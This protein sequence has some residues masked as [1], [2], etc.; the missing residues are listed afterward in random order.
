MSL[1]SL[2]RAFSR[3]LIATFSFVRI[4][5]AILTFPKVPLPSDFPMQMRIKLVRLNLNF[6]YPSLTKD[7]VA[8][9]DPFGMWIYFTF[10]CFGSVCMRARH[11]KV[12]ILLLLF[13]LGCPNT[14]SLSSHSRLVCFILIGDFWPLLYIHVTA[15][16]ATSMSSRSTG[17]LCCRTIGHRLLTLRLKTLA[18]KLELLL[19]SFTFKLI[20]R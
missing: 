2:I 9:S 7:V 1:R 15:P 6:S 18:L 5:S 20:I 4:C 17:W 11:R 13:M 19:R 3:I 14:R 8:K 16:E 12:F 10:R